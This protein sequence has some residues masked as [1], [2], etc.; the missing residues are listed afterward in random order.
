MDHHFPHQ[1]DRREISNTPNQ[2]IDLHALYII[3]L[4][5]GLFYLPLIGFN[6]ADEYQGIV[7]FD[8]LHS[9]LGVERMDYDFVVIKTRFV[10][11]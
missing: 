11:D 5:Q 10:R 4:L 9:T 7:F 3:Q 1:N 6:I 2:R 8:L